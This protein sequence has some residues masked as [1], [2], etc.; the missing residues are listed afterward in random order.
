[1]RSKLFS[2]VAYLHLGELFKRALPVVG[3][4]VLTRALGPADYGAYALIMSL[5][6]L[7]PMIVDFGTHKMI[8]TR[9]PGI[10]GDQ[11]RAEIAELLAAAA[12]MR[13]LAGSLVVAGAPLLPFLAGWI[14][15]RPELGTLAVTLCLA[16]VLT[17]PL[18]LAAAVLEA[19]GEMKAV[20]ALDA[21]WESLR[22]TTLLALVLAGAGLRGLVLGLAA[23][24]AMQSMIGIMAYRRYSTRPAARL[25]MLIEVVR[26]FPAARVKPYLKLGL[27]VAASKKLD[28]FGR[29]ALTLMVGAFA[30]VSEVG[31][32]RIAMALAAAPL[33]L[34]SPVSRALF[35]RLARL[36]ATGR[37]VAY[38]R[39]LKGATLATGLGFLL[40]VAGFALGLPSLVAIL[41]GEAFLPAVRIA[42]LL[43]GGVAVI[44]FS[45]ARDALYLFH[46]KLKRFNLRNF[47][48]LAVWIP[49]AYLL[50]RAYQTTG[51]A[52]VLT[53]GTWSM[54]FA[55]SLALAALL[56]DLRREKVT[57]LAESD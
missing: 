48:F 26:C 33:A 43:L 17:G 19:R 18:H 46:G 37:S 55:D 5:G 8:V 51:A 13:L 27:G 6:A 44:G 47:A 38:A 40:S 25:P 39:Y 57:V 24:T 3:S 35:V 10:V 21:L 11:K 4:V 36:R 2:D 28:Q 34:L 29:A 30:T 54:L 42:W 45:V 50:T 15:S 22:L 56:R 53:L 7:L 16:S 31:F 32:L 14:Y 12:K 9:L 1:M 23:V 41:Y 52:I 20:A 49:V